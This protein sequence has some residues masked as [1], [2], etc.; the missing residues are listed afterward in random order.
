MIPQ[1]V[2]VQ[3]LHHAVWQ[4]TMTH[5]LRGQDEKKNVY[6]PVSAQCFESASRSKNSPIGMPHMLYILREYRRTDCRG[7][8]S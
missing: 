6:R 4:G 8:H 2:I 5:T 7:E 3:P 1:S